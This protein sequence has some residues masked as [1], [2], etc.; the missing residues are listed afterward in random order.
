MSLSHYSR[1]EGG[2]PG[3]GEVKVAGGARI[4]PRQ[5]GADEGEQTDASIGG[6]EDT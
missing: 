5:R 4:L 3:E 1:A 2:V 6:M